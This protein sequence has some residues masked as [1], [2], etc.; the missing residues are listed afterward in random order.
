[1]CTQWSQN[2]RVLQ[3]TKEGGF[4]MVELM[5]VVGIIAIAVLLAT[6]NFVAWKQRNQLKQE[7][8]VLHTNMNLSRMAA[9]SRNQTLTVTVALNAGRV[10]A[11][12]TD[13]SS[14]FAT[15][16]A[17]TSSCVLPTQVMASDVIGVSGT[18]T[19]QF[20]SLGLRSGGG[21]ANLAITLS[22]ARGNRFDIQVTPAGKSRWC[23]SSPC[24][25]N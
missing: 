9:M 7:L 18:T 10:T 16:L 13:P 15:C 8:I 14:T 2:S 5:T 19:F 6:P 3:W 25:V 4:T 17:S 1:M 20:T 21:A 23:T 11:T 22:D 24:P 12:F